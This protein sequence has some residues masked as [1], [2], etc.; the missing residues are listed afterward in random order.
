MNNVLIYCRKRNIES[1]AE[2]TATLLQE[3]LQQL[4]LTVDLTHSLNVPR[5]LVNS[6]QTV[7][8]VVE[9]LPLS[10]NEALHLA[11]CKTLGKSTVLSVLNSDQRI[12]KNYLTYIKPDAFSVSQTNHLK[13][14]RYITGNKFIFSAF[15]QSQSS[16]KKSSIQCEAF[17]V[18]LQGK[19]EEAIEFKTEKSIYFDGR[20][21]LQ[22]NN[23]S[24][25]RKKWAEMI[26]TQKISAQSHLILSENKLNQLIADEALAVVLADPSLSH[27]EFTEWLNK[28]L[29]RKNLILL[30]EYQAT[31]FSY[32][33]ASGQNCIVLPAESWI[34]DLQFL[35]IP[36]DISATTYK[37]ADLFEPSINELS[38]LYSKLWHQKTSLLTSGSVKL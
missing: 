22:K 21:L 16:S 37:P 3:Q 23:S 8:M 15:P 9:N 30:N 25:L 32:F 1:I 7:H 12:G 2:Q 14:F 36:A 18:P 11:V 33:W 34:K 20:K 26:N 19:L 31:G 35:E 29:N 17:L 38:R 28:C 13:F 27:T 24:Q 5:L 4:G 6:Y 10:L